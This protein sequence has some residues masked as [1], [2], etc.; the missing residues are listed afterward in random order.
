MQYKVSIIVPCWNVENY[1]DRCVESLVNQTLRDIEIIL[2]DDESPDN[3]PHMCESWANKDKRIKVIHKKNQGLG[4]ACNTGLSVAL[5]EYIAFCDSDDWV[6][7]N[8]YE[9]MYNL[10][11]SKN[12]DMV[13]TGFKYVDIN[14]KPIS[15]AK[16]C[17]S[18]EIYKE[19]GI[20]EIM[21]GMIAAPPESTQER[22][23]QASA[24]LCLYKNSIIKEERLQFVSERVIPS[25]DLSFNI[26]YL[27]HCKRVYT[28]PYCFYNYRYDPISITRSVKKNK[29]TLAKKLY[30][31]LCD[32]A[33]ILNLGRDGELRIQR[34]FIG[35]IRAI[36]ANA[37]KSSISKNEKQE[38]LKEIYQDDVSNDVIKKYPFHLMPIKHKLFLLVL[39]SQNYSLLNILS[40]FMH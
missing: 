19:D 9:Y 29:F 38:I 35:M 3:V 22:Q 36:V 10:A 25:E 12:L 32:K 34:L 24:K 11:I 17:Y 27:S 6:D 7:S 39:S 26:D 28:S 15:K 18:E 20:K 33:I 37:L 40:K 23:F 21:K 4:F 5:G 30:F 14:G 1:L 8:T 2:V 13:M 31:H 16:T